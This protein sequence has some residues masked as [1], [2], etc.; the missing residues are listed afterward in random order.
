[1]GGRIQAHLQRVS[2]HVEI[3]IS[4]TGQGIVAD[5]LPHVFERFQQ[6]DSTSTRRHTGLGLGLALVRHLVELHG[7]T[8]EASSPGEGQGATFVV[9]LPVAIARDG[10][11]DDTRPRRGHL[12]WTAA[13]SLHGLRA[14]VV[15]DDRDGLDLIAAILINAGAEVRTMGSAADGLEAIRTWRPDVLISD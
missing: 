10:E 9:K 13:P 5:V 1:R 2:S 14:V 15:D 4:D 6:A 12:A 8:V 3:T 11:T 7:G